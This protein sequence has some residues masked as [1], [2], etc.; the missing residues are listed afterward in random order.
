MPIAQEPRN[1]H[2]TGNSNH[3]SGAKEVRRECEGL[4]ENGSQGLI[5]RGQSD[6]K[7]GQAGEKAGYGTGKGEDQ[8]A[9]ERQD[10]AA[11]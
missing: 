11:D 4:V 10:S 8:T 6:S 9:G 3:K 2:G 5:G 7:C 1:A